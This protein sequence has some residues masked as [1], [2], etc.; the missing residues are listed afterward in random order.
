MEDRDGGTP[1]ALAG[2]EPVAQSVVLRGATRAPLVEELD[3]GLDAGALREP[4]KWSRVRETPVARQRLAG[5][6]GVQVLELWHRPVFGDDRDDA[7]D[8]LGDVDDH[9][10]RQVKGAREVEV[11]LVV[12]GHGHDRAGAVVGQHVV[13]CPDR[14]SLAAQRV[15]GEA[16]EVN[17]RLRTVARLAVDGVEGASVREVRREAFAHL[18]AGALGQLGRQV[19]VWSDDHEG[20]AVERV[21]AR[22]EDRDGSIA[23]FDDEV[24]VCTERAPD[25][26]ALHRDDLLR[27][28]P[29]ELVEVV[30]ETVGVVGDLEVPLVEL[31][32]HDDR[33]AAL[34]VAVDDLLVGEHRLVVRAPVDV[35]VLSVREAP[36]VHLQ[37]QPLVPA[38]VLRVGGVDDAVPVEGRRVALHG[39]ALL[40]D[41]LVRP[42][43]GVT[44]VL[45]GG[46]LGGQ[47]EGVPAD[48]VQ[49]VEA[50][51]APVA[52]DGVAE[53]V[54]LG[55]AH[56]QVA[57]RVR[58]HVEDVLAGAV[59]TLE[60]RRERLKLVPLSRP[61]RF[62]SLEVVFLGLS[63]CRFGHRFPLP[64]S[65]RLLGGG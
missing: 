63:A 39:R 53:R 56:V 51:V 1:V 23:A 65:C 33:V 31:L 44:T 14:Q 3:G 34:A 10:D 62:E 60:V 17:A 22:R 20:R 7:G 54:L 25:P 26:V 37:E 32:L 61:L 43:L 45:D 46:V 13:G 29:L 35:G 50:L 52:C 28:V 49:D 42:V 36:L 16:A 59:V 64:I 18:V 57:G 41:V 11:A 48:G 27:P 58:E 2:D 5:L 47:A 15:D 12:G 40:R 8:G 24:D 55:M 19:G 9:L 6:G 21:W 38:V 30:D 4:V